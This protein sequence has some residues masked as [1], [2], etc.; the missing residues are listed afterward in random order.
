MANHHNLKI[1]EETLYCFPYLTLKNDHA[2]RGNIQ[3]FPFFTVNFD[4]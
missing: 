4:L 3:L 1:Q 2:K